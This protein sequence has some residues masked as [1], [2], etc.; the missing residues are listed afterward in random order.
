M[1]YD[2]ET[3][4]DRRENSRKWI[5][6]RKYDDIIVPFSVADMEFMTAPEIKRELKKYIDDNILGYTVKTEEYLEEIVKWQNKIHNVIIKKDYIVPT[7]GVVN[8]LYNAVL[9]YT[10]EGDGVIVFMPSYPPFIQS[11]EYAKRNPV[12]ISLKNNSG[13][14][15][16]DFS[17]F[18]EE[19]SKKENTMIILCNPH[20][21]VGRVWKK[22]ELEKIF[23]IASKNNL[24]IISDEIWSDITFNGIKTSSFFNISKNYKKLLVSTSA[25][26]TFNLAGLGA[27]NIIIPDYEYRKKFIKE[28]KK[29]HVSVNALGLAG[30]Y[31]AYKYGEEWMKEMLDVV[32]NNYKYAKEFLEN[33]IK[34]SVVS[35][36]EGTYAIWVDLRCL[37][38]KP[39]ELEKFMVENA[40][41]YTNE[42]YKFGV[43]GEGFERINIA[44]PEKA[45]KRA[46]N[47]LKDALDS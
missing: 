1:K 19:A 45:L 16:F 20:N 12:K 7:P 40:C 10:C 43:E 38:K 8:A 2:F 22:E 29:S 15:T 6:V 32:Y 42:G 25:S 13:Y 11:I 24:F 39:E 34:G 36:L 5:P 44:V 26:K 31:A 21:P 37:G 9:S 47:R 17:K 41:F 33:N 46:L 18:E 28:M 23:E 30:T 14:Y 3:I 27:S 35:P 4:Y